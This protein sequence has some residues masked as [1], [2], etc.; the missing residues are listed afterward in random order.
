MEEGLG[1]I[2]SNEK[3]RPKMIMI[4]VIMGLENKR[5]SVCCRKRVCVI[6]RG[7]GKEKP[8]EGM[9]M[10]RAHHIYI[11]ICIYLYLYIYLYI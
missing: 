5:G 6:R 7:R 1:S 10:I 11:C 9:S 3:K 4:T 2:P 8:L